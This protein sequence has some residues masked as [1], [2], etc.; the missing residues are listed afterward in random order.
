MKCF[1]NEVILRNK[2]FCKEMVLITILLCEK[3]TDKSTTVSEIYL[4][5]DEKLAEALQL[6]PPFMHWQNNDIG[7]ITTVFVI[8][9]LYKSR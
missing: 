1:T 8:Y 4:L 5:K 9:L 6:F 2:E 3:D 7:S